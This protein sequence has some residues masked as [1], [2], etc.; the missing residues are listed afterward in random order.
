MPT[1]NTPLIFVSSPGDVAEERALAE[2]VLRRLAEEYRGT[3]QF[4]T[5]LW[6]HE[7]MFAHTGFQEQI[8]RPSECDLVICI[9]WSRLGTRLPQGFS[10]GMGESPPT[11]TE[12]E[13][14][15]ALQ[16]YR[17]AGKPNLLIYRKT[18]AP[19]LS[20]AS[21]EARERLRQYELLEAFCRRT[22]FDEHGAII[23][24]HTTYSESYEFE[25]R[26]AEHV[27]RWLGQ[28]VGG[29]EPLARWTTGSPYR[30]LRV[31]EAEHRE[32]YFGRSQS[33]SELIGC[34]RNTETSSATGGRI[35]RFLLVQGMSGN[36]K[37]SL[38]RAGLLPLLQG[39]A[40]EGIGL[41]RQVV[42]MPSDRANQRPNAGV[43]GALM[44]ELSK[45]IPAIGR[46]YPDIGQLADRVR[47]APGE[48]AARLDGYLTQEATNIG[49]RPDQIRLIVFI[50]QLEEIFDKSVPVE[51]RQAFIA[52]LDAMAREG[53]VWV[54]ATV[55]SDFAPRLE[56][57]APLIS[58]AREGYLYIL[59]PPRADELAEM[60][61]EPARAAGLKWDFRDGVSLDQLILREAIANPEGLPLLEYALDQLYERHS[62]RRLTYE[63][64]E[65]LGG[66]K[67][68][69]A[70]A[71][72]QVFISQA[73]TGSTFRSL[74]RSLISV[75]D[76]GTATRRYAPLHELSP[77]TPE[78]AF[79]D[80]LIE[81][82][83][84]VADHR[85]DKPVASFAHEALISSWPRVVDFLAEEADLLQ[86]RE[87]AL[88]DARLWQ[89]HGELVAWL[90]TADKLATFATLESAKIVLPEPIPRFIEASRGRARRVSQIRSII[91]GIVILL[92]LVASGAGWIATNRERVAE[93]Q[94]ARTLEA[95]SRLLTQ[96]ASEQLKDGNLSYAR[97]IILEVLA[98]AKSS[99]TTNNAAISVF[100]DVRASDS[101]L[102]VLSGHT[103]GV[104]Q[105]TFS[106]DGTHVVTGG[107]DGTARI[108]D[109]RTGIQIA[110]LRGH[111]AAPF[112]AYSPDGLRIVTASD[113]VRIWDAG[114]GTLIASFGDADYYE[115]AYYSP[116]GGTILASSGDLT[117]WD[118]RTY[119]KINS[120]GIKSIQLVSATY[121]PDG[122]R[123]VA[124][125]SD[126]S[127]RVF[128]ARTGVQ[129]AV[130]SGHTGRI[131]SVRFSPDGSRILTAS[132]DSTARISDSRSGALV[133][134]LPSLGQMWSAAY[135]PDGSS[136]ITTSTDTT[137]RIWDASTG[138]L[139]RRLSGHFD[140]LS[141]ASYS[142]DGS[143]I[144]TAAYDQTARIWDARISPV[145]IVLKGHVGR[146]STIAYSPD[147]S[148]V[149]TASEDKTARIWD[150][151]RGSQ[152]AV[153][154]GH[155]GAV[156]S[157]S[158]SP[159]GKRV[160]TAASD[161]VRIWDSLTLA[162]LTLLPN[163]VEGFSDASFSSDGQRI[164]TSEVDFSVRVWD[165]PTFAKPLMLKGHSSWIDSVKFSP[166][167]A[168][169]LSGSVDNTARIWDSRTGR[170]L[171]ILPHPEHVNAVAYAPDGTRIATACSDKLVRIWDGVT[172]ALIMVLTG[173]RAF[174]YDVAFSQDGKLIVT[175]GR[176]GTVRIW[177]AVTGGELAAVLGRETHASSS[178]SFS[179]DG[180]H[181]ASATDTDARIW[182]IGHLADLS[183]Q[184]AWA[185]SAESDPMTELERTQLG[186]TVKAVK[187][188]FSNASECD[189]QAG[190][191]YDPDRVAIG[192]ERERIIVDIARSACRIESPKSRNERETYETGRAL[193]AAGDDKAA[194]AAFENALSRG[195]RVAG[196][197]LADLLSVS[198]NGPSDRARIEALYTQ[199]WK[200]GVAIA[201]FKLGTFYDHN[202]AHDADSRAE[203]A[204]A[205][206]QRGADRGEPHALAVLAERS[207]ER[208]IERLAPEKATA[209]LLAAFALY[210]R[211]AN[212]AV[213]DDWPEE[214]W[215]HWRYRR[216]SI[217]RYL[218]TEGMMQQ[219]ANSFQR[220]VGR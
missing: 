59:G 97:A 159:D 18:A 160:V 144:V 156:S 69:V 133:L 36:G 82:R 204:L 123:I 138:T 175:A 212:N 74:M 124:A 37:S 56:E 41:W 44:E 210:A 116:D 13:V 29:A 61:T 73:G 134:V 66:L 21:V 105:A 162:P 81:R 146:L 128:D 107:L 155:K 88:R 43:V 117:T 150:A 143:R 12:F 211:A 58:L 8:Q 208:A 98:R 104:R 194:K 198:E 49:L 183:A 127:A 90:A 102:A 185:K 96:T 64:Y 26:L 62:G 167:G 28:Q 55:R 166:D 86:S 17:I 132:V 157:A 22:F 109:A 121:S 168:R 184:I 215:R 111:K 76:A 189:R 213:N 197:D 216:S 110:V 182:E 196:I 203:T 180:S 7:P 125:A 6:E 149:V 75:D 103:A 3:F 71:A 84:C 187:E 131:M 193:L 142:P 19:Q 176:D 161:G 51:E 152:V 92:A 217:A 67:G 120:I 77:D 112:A 16:A 172:G 173:H 169:V 87:S 106:P 214:A 206:Y 139:M 10:P 199:A 130:A 205:W 91:A 207:E 195:Y 57:H 39:R 171:A 50:D 178:V 32:I 34:L 33:L 181:I 129:Q 53:R 27:R 25:K 68:G 54:I 9:L 1:T 63:G 48:S 219:V 192:V 65:Q 137:A 45:I 93:I 101:Q 220:A 158:Y 38:I 122:R 119:A 200:K 163:S 115:S 114:T 177:D 95:Q 188:T 80:A 136:I 70:K 209:E 164:V 60:I 170:Q 46:S 47:A 4:Q 35:T 218:S 126:N 165:A 85:G 99:Q 31:F 154:G 23:V 30:G 151:T 153:L 42:L 140:I 147:G 202:K 89:Q 100:Q 179:P 174:V 148:R 15:D 141:T 5:V 83:L 113:L 145:G 52:I 94:T 2:G 72:E 108:W 190:A 118:S 11:G 78:R 20:M 79:L 186:L 135:S 40:I 191:Y 24:A 201:A 14:N